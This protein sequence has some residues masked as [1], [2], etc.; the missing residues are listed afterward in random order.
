MGENVWDFPIV[1]NGSLSGVTLAGFDTGFEPGKGHLGGL[2]EAG[3]LYAQVKADNSDPVNKTILANGG[4]AAA[5]NATIR[6]AFQSYS[7]NAWIFYGGNGYLACTSTRIHA[8]GARV[9]RAFDLE[10]F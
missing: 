10:T 5:Y 4:T 8:Y 9:F 2:A 3:L 7:G 6:L 1:H